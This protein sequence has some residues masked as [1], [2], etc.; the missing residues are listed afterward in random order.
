M[1]E[2]QDRR[3]FWLVLGLVGLPALPLLWG[4]SWWENLLLNLIRTPM[5]DEWF[6]TAVVLLLASDTL[7]PVPS[8]VIMTLSG[9]RLGWLWGSGVSWLGLT[10][11]GLALFLLVQWLGQITL[12]RWL[13]PEELAKWKAAS[14]RWGPVWLVATRP[15]PLVAEAAVAL[16]ALQQMPIRHFALALATSNLL[17]AI[18]YGV[19][20][21]IAVEHEWLV[22]ALVA[23][24]ALPMLLAAWLQGRKRHVRS[25][26]NSRPT[27]T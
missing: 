23:S 27:D 16:A 26:G 11:G 8:S 20:G 10:C 5:S 13:A 21:H 18:L 17:L 22:W 1:A 7:L 24:A 14:S 9:A 3:I 4:V 2:R 12:R 6:A 15:I 25:E 19:L